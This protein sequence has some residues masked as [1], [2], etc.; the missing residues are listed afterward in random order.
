MTTWPCIEHGYIAVAWAWSFDQFLSLDSLSPLAFA[1][2][3]VIATRL[4]HP[5]NDDQIQIILDFGCCSD[6]LTVVT[7]SDDEMAILKTQDEADRIF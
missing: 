5:I 2:T 4:N 6:R 3:L 7:L 1:P